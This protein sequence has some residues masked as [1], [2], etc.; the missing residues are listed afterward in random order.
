MLLY[1]ARPRIEEY[2][3]SESALLTLVSRSDGF[4]EDIDLGGLAAVLVDDSLLTGNNG[5]AKTERERHNRFESST[6]KAES[7]TEFSYAGAG[8]FQTTPPSIVTVEQRAYIGNNGFAKTERE[9]HNRFESL[10][11]KAE[12]LTEFSYAWAGIFQTTPP[13]IVTVEQRA[14][15]EAL[16]KQ[17]DDSW[18]F[19]SARSLRGGL[20]WLDNVKRPDISS[21]VAKLVQVKDNTSPE[22]LSVHL[23]MV[24]SA[25]AFLRSKCDVGLVFPVLQ[26]DFRLV[27]Y[28]YASFGTNADHTRQLGC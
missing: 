25:V 15:I 8:I 17:D 16:E 28:S 14:Y 4:V 11:S 19:A 12:S 24:R 22:E 6:S 27:C 3:A 23:K 26:N 13:S 7:L 9:R 20:S 5:F 21:V 18:D 2:S 1:F 10:T